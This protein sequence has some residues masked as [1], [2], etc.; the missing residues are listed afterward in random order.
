MRIAD[1][2]IMQVLAFL[3]VLIAIPIV[4]F[5]LAVG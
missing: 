1:I 2:T 5:I 3:A 4:L